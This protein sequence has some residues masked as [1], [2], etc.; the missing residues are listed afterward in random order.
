MEEKPRAPDDRFWKQVSSSHH[1][2]LILDYDGTLA[3][4]RVE[5][6]EA[7]PL[8]GVSAAIKKIMEMTATTVAIVSG[9]PISELDQLAPELTSEVVVT[10]SH[11]WERRGPTGALHVAERPPEIEGTLDKSRT[12]AKLSIERMLGNPGKK[13]LERKA[14]SVAVH[15][16]GLEDALAERLLK[17]IK[18]EW[19]NIL[20]AG[21]EIMEFNGGLEIRAKGRD[22][23]AA[24]RDLLDMYPE[25]DLPVYIGDDL[26]DE[27]AFRELSGKG[28][29]IKVGEGE[30]TASY[31]LPDCEAVKT[32][33]DNWNKTAKP[34]NNR[35]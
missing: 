13:R 35:P 25:T 17:E 7:V 19:G 4:F 28:V 23:G 18:N 8:P 3:P 20:A 33:L 27:D 24:V 1:P 32:F 14:A 22:K 21:T 6:M 30:T 10:G 31:R 2:L 29:G 11:G 15:T 26:T 34:E 9:R 16:R 12:V 5:R